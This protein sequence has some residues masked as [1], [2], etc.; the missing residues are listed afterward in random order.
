MHL[1]WK[2]LDE[3][4]KTYI[5]WFAWLCSNPVLSCWVFRCSTLVC[6][7]SLQVWELPP[8]VQNNTCN[9]SEELCVSWMKDIQQVLILSVSRHGM[10]IK[11]QT[12]KTRFHSGFDVEII[13]YT[14]HVTIF[15]C[16]TENTH[17][18][19][20]QQSTSCFSGLKFLAV[21]LPHPEVIS[22][23]EGRACTQGVLP[24]QTPKRE[25][26]RRPDPGREIANTC[27]AW[28]NVV[29]P[30]RRNCWK[31]TADVATC[32]HLDCKQ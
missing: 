12:D 11:Q 18:H 26:P 15:P 22:S 20:E 7:G 31:H 9:H 6:M 8:T 2:S 3:L 10:N 30:T 5:M 14:I 28:G 21:V 4:K 29:F 17:T 19:R 27:G 13:S 23:A 32:V 16:W 1:W 25:C 24:K